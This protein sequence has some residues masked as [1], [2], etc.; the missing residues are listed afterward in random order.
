M[1]RELDVYLYRHL[2]GKLVQDDHGEMT[3]QYTKD[4]MKDKQ[5][6][7]LSQ[8][9]PLQSQVFTRKECIGFFNGILPE[10]GKREIV[11][12]NLGISSKNDVKM[13]EL[14]GGECAGAVTFLPSGESLPAGN[15]EYH[16]LTEAELANTLRNLPKRPLLAGAS[17]VRL[18]LAGAQDKLAVYV[19]DGQISIPLEGSPSTHIL[20]P[21]IREFDAIVVNELLCMRLARAVGL[22]TASVILGRAEDVE[23]LLV[24]RYD[25]VKDVSRGLRRLHQEDF[26]QALGTVSDNKYQADGGPSIA[27]CVALLRKACTTPVQDILHFLD[28]IIFNYLIGNNDA[29]GKNF[30]LLYKGYPPELRTTVFAPLYDLVSTIYYPDLSPRMAM[31]LGGEYVAEKIRP[32]NFDQLAEEAKIGKPRFRRRVQELARLVQSTLPEVTPG[33]PAGTKV[34]TC[35]QQRCEHTIEMFQT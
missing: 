16:T 4:W 32:K 11:A 28:S 33:D 15:S 18:S 30:S 14:I 25:R 26:C 27:D 3:F 20:K 19:T 24:E 35:I 23:Y 29:H 8:S 2:V 22:P 5:A 34:A 7:P 21:A 1:A 12:K 13:L 31:K 9:L 6:V 17:R 10:G